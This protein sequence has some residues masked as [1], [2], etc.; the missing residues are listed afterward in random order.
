MFGYRYNTSTF[1]NKEGASDRVSQRK[2]LVSKLH[3]E[4]N[5][6]A[7]LVQQHIAD[8]THRCEQCGIMDDFNFV[9]KEND[10]PTSLDLTDSKNQIIW[11]NSPDRWEVGNL[12][13][14]AS[15][16]TLENVQAARNIVRQTVKSIRVK[17]KAGS[18]EADCLVSFQNRS[19][20]YDLLLGSW[21]PTM[22]SL[23]SKYL[24]DHD[25]DGVVLYYC[26]L[27]EFAGASKENIIDA[28]QQL[29][30]A[31]VQLRLYKNDVKAFTNAIRIPVRQLANCQEVP[32]FQHFLNVYHGV[33]DCP[34][35]EFRSYASDL[36]RDY[37]DDGPASK[38]SMLELLAKFDAEYT[39]LKS[40]NRWTKDTTQ[41]S[42]IIALT[43]EITNLKTLIANLAN[44]NASTQPPPTKG[45]NKPTFIPKE[46][47]KETATVN[48]NQWFY[49]RTCFGGKGAWNKTHT[50]A[51]HVVGAGKGF[52]GGK[53][54]PP[55]TTTPPPSSDTTPT[56]STATANLATQD[57]TS[58]ALGGIF[59]V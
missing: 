52:K 11:N 29:T 7:D 36:Y 21:T 6:E 44:K 8:I 27:K 46:G 50:T 55:L 1:S 20:F 16:A 5:G 28:Y 45:S 49:C 19:W 2:A 47:E 25:K 22:L 56:G 32:T 15:K 42:E 39:R 35:E 3:H 10:P 54:T 12:L 24:E 43:A 13:D 18:F 59:L 33:M 14:D 4:F 40:L 34:N 9:I 58:D 48:E 23:M 26:F 30:E 41:D 57:D 17:P 53:K 31:K 38:W 51:Q 37:R